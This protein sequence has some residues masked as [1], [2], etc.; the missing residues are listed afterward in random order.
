MSVSEYKLIPDGAISI[1]LMQL[2]ECHCEICSYGKYQFSI[3][4]NYNTGFNHL[5]WGSEIV[6]EQDMLEDIRDEV[7][8]ACKHYELN[9]DFNKSIYVWDLDENSKRKLL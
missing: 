9:I 1:E 6:R 2:A 4:A 3:W 8:E 5:L 7:I